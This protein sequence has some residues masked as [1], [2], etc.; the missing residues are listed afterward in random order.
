LKTSGKGGTHTKVCVLFLEKHKEKPA[1]DMFMADVKW[2]GH[3]SRGNPTLRKNNLGQ[4]TL[5][6]EV[7][8]VAPR[9]YALQNGKK[10]ARDHLGYYLS[11]KHVR[12][13]ILVP[14][15]YSPEIEESLKALRPTHDLI[16]LGSL[17]DDGSLSITTGTEIGKMAYGTG[18]IP[19]IRTSDLSNWELKAD[20]KHGV[21][22]ELYQDAKKQCDVKAG[23]ILM[24]R[25]GTYLIGTLAVVTKN[26]LPMLFQSHLFRIRVLKP[27]K[28]NPY[29][30]FVCLNAPV[31]KAQV[32]SKQFTQDI[33]DTLGNR[34]LELIL[35]IPKDAP[36]REH[37]AKRAQEIIDCRARYRDE[38]SQLPHDLQ[39]TTLDII[40]ALEE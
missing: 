27:E 15:Y 2:C 3:D 37:L 32:R 20:F 38:A 14:K 1:Y 10:I 25:D 21:S 35:P 7:P 31:V 33:I 34:V 30:L 26:D 11:S 22:E 8:L 9:Y 24:V 16:T 19:F 5:L 29:L 4:L 12:K 17:V 23:D 18:A 13:Q 6:D 39:G 36:Q 40:D 28:I